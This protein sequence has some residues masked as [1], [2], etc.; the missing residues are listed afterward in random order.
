[1]P[2]PIVERYKYK[3]MG[4]FFKAPSFFLRIKGI[5][6]RFTSESNDGMK[7][8]TAPVRRQSPPANLTTAGA[9]QKTETISF[10]RIFFLYV[11]KKR[12]IHSNPPLQ[13]P[14]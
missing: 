5:W 10:R 1:M 7:N 13:L 12:K 8:E 4:A 2:Q 11:E 3:T 14:V 6:T 9:E